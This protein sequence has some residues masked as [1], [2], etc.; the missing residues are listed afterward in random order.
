MTTRVKN[1]IHKPIQKLTLHTQLSTPIA[2]EPTTVTQ[3]LKDPQWCRAMSKEYDAL[4]RNG[5]WELVPAD[6]SHNVVGCKWIFHIKRHSDGSVDRFKARLVA[7]G[8][9]QRPGVDYHDTFSPVVKPTTIR[10]VL[11]LAV[12]Q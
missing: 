9:H 11:S 6:P 10:L 4:V 7:K 2:L 12:S 5:T 1:N 3:A 8:F